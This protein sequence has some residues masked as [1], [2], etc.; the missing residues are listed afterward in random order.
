MGLPLLHLERKEGLSYSV[1][2]G[3]PISFSLTSFDRVMTDS[4][5]KRCLYRD[6]SH[7]RLIGLAQYCPDQFVCDPRWILTYSNPCISS[8]KRRGFTWLDKHWD[9]AKRGQSPMALPRCL[10]RLCQGRSTL[11]PF[12][13]RCR[14]SRLHQI[15]THP[16]SK[17]S[18][19]AL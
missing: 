1:S 4:S 2:F 12:S 19:G 5:Q 16:F 18:G 13:R 15:Q 8:N 7:F 3:D 14:F 6:K 17:N 10:P 9:K 11:P